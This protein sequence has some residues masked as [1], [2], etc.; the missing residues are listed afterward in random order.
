MK[1]LLLSM[2]SGFE[3]SQQE[4]A[5]KKESLR[6]RHH[7]YIIRSDMQMKNAIEFAYVLDLK[8]EYALSP[9][10]AE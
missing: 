6:L 5:E 2:F 3:Y 8:C 1:L 10:G 4:G 9:T 7:E